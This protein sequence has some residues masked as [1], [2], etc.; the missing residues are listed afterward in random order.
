MFIDSSTR[1]ETLRTLLLQEQKFL[2]CVCFK[3]L[4]ETEATLE[5]LIPRCIKPISTP[6]NCCSVCATCNAELGTMSLQKKLDH[7]RS[8]YE[9]LVR[10]LEKNQTLVYEYIVNKITFLMKN[11][12]TFLKKNNICIIKKKN[13]KL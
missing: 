5:H 7:I 11:E 10:P 6:E 2:C 3:A 1:Y 4:D 13:L 12:A 8:L 9:E